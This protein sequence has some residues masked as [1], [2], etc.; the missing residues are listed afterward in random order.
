MFELLAFLGPLLAA[1]RP[2]DLVDIV[3]IAV[4]F[5]FAWRWLR[6]RTSRVGLAAV[7]SC[8]LLYVVA[9]LLNMY[10][11]LLLF[12]AGFMIILLAAV[13]VFQ[14]DLRRLFSRLATLGLPAKNP[15]G[16][17]ADKLTEALCRMAEERIGALVVLK[18]REAVDPFIEGGTRVDG[19]V[20]P[21]LLYSIFHPASPG[22]DGA[23]LIDGDRIDR[24]GIHLP[25]SHN[26]AEIGDFGMRH[27][28][29]LGLSE[30]CDALVLI[31]SEERGTLRVAERGRLLRLDSAAEL[32]SRLDEYY[33]ERQT[34]PNGRGWQHVFSRHLTTK[35]A[36]VC[37]AATLWLVLVNPLHT[38]EQHYN[39]PIEYRN[40]PKNMAVEDP[41]PPTV[42][43]RLSGPERIF[44]LFNAEGA[45]VSLDLSA[46]RDGRQEIPV[47]DESLT[48]PPAL[49]VERLEPRQI[50]IRAHQLVPVELPIEVDTR[51]KPRSPLTLTG[52]TVEPAKVTVLL[53]QSQQRYIRQINTDV[54][55]LDELTKSESRKVELILPPYARFPETP[56]PKVQVTLTLNGTPPKP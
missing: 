55:R 29:G 39:I 8:S 7:V 15:S 44:R 5:Y 45:V 19:R 2:A 24:L 37:V 38:V 25:L 6:H 13:L 41:S 27:T 26:L 18:G 51:G 12:Q 36:S 42:K 23:V 4:F 11:T 1:V 54:I 17:S 46:I 43:V 34:G 47:P 21:V 16:E 33:R 48:R 20:S 14:E 56:A 3:V 9:R 10:L 50:S 49:V 30:Q 22:H 52:M 28:A 40:I 35:V 53:P 31:V 32:R